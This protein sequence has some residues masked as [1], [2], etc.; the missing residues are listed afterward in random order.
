MRCLARNRQEFYYCLYKGTEKVTEE[1]DKK[2]YETGEVK[3]TYEQPIPLRANISSDKGTSQLEVF[4]NF[5][6]YDRV[7]VVDDVNCPIDENTV[8]FIGETPSYDSDG[9]PLYNFIVKRKSVSLNSV[10]YAI[11]KVR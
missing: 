7:I 11:R 1:I 9:T 2:S 6:D 4:G 3:I 5:E 8:L 10:S